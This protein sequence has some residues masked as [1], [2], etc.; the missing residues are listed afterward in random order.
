[1]ANECCHGPGYATPL[2]AYKSGAREKLIYVPC[3]YPDQKTQPDYLATIDVD[4]E[5][6]TY[7]KVIHRLKMPFVGDELHH[8]GWNACSSCHNDPSKSRSKLILPAVNSSR[9]YV[10][11][12][13]SDPRA[14][15]IHKVVDG[16]EIKEKTGL[17]YPH[18]THCLGSGDIMISAMGSP[19][20]EAKGGFI[21]LDEEFNIK[22]SWTNERTPYGY[23]FWYQPRHNIMVA[24][25]F[26]APNSFMKGFDPSEAGTRYGDSLHLWDW[27]EKKLVQSIKLGQAGM[28]PLEVRFAHN[29]DADY[30]FVGCALSS[31]VVLV[32][33][34]PSAD[35][36]FQLSHKFVINQSWLAVEG[37]ALPQL[38]PLITDILLSLDD[39]F[40]FFSNWLRG[41]ICQ[42]DITDPENPK[43]V[44]RV[45][46]G[47]SLRK[48]GSAKALDPE[49]DGLVDG[50]APAVQVQGKDIQGGPQMIQ[51]S[52]DG[53]R[54]YVTNSLISPWDHQFYPDLI[55]KGSQMVQVDVDTEKGGLTV[56]QNFLVDFGDEPDGPVLAHE[57]RY[58]GGDCSSDIWL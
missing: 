12:T 30:G 10:V 43:L 40:L 48:G 42:Y 31:N 35:G 9:I 36:S 41:D 39:K 17:A 25:E 24:S 46:L 22:G 49:A 3:I 13:S 55:K 50:Y 47:G 44:G 5:S 8:S 18:T 52:L 51:L 11:D 4:P 27:K 6:A 33:K 45:Y 38:P 14:P 23:D 32:R 15:K 16:A 28:I 29:P 20:G 21:I 2:D 53:K 57:A 34:Q 58:P 26:G 1:M 19:D 56:N 7:S 54:L 37:W